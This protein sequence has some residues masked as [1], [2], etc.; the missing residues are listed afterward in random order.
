MLSR[1]HGRART[2]LYGSWAR[3]Q[4]TRHS[5]IDVGIM[6]IEP[7]DPAELSDLR[8]TL[9]ESN[10]LLPVDVVDLSRTDAEFREHVL[11]D[12]IEWTD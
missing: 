4:A 8:Q 7:L 5:D 1:L 10:I 12:A 6:P 3:G 9:E 11:Q 2:Y